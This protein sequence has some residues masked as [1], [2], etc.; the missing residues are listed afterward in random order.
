M[1]STRDIC[2]A[3]G[4]GKFSCHRL[5]WDLCHGAWP[6][7]GSSFCTLEEA[8]ARSATKRIGDFAYHKSRYLFASRGAW[9]AAAEGFL[10]GV[11]DLA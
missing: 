8:E 1:W 5:M 11:R 3:E 10:D 7:W 9:V 4:Q 6:D 2:A